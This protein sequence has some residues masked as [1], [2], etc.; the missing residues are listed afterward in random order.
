MYF[1]LS[2]LM[3]DFF[4]SVFICIIRSIRVSI[5]LF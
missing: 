3:K 5:F 2:L 1:L 4:E